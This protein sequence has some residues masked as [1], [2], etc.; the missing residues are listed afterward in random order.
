MK[1]I[2]DVWSEIFWAGHNFHARISPDYDE[3]APDGQRLTGVYE[4]QMH[5]CFSYKRKTHRSWTEWW[6]RK[7]NFSNIKL[8]PNHYVYQVSSSHLVIDAIDPIPL[9]RLRESYEH[10][11]YRGAKLEQI[12]NEIDRQIEA[13]EYTRN[14]FSAIESEN[15]KAIEILREYRRDIFDKGY[16]LTP[17]DPDKIRRFRL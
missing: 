14:L 12:L 2:R 9:Y 4:N 1:D 15:W 10:S 13:L 11:A 3:L 17:I 5:M 6:I 7:V 8:A 16:P